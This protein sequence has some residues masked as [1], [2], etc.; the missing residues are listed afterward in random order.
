MLSEVL[1]CPQLEG[2][3]ESTRIA[4]CVVGGKRQEDEW[5]LKCHLARFR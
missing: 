1:D 5:S 2:G 3:G 4:R